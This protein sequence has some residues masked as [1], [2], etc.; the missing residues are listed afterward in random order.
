[1]GGGLNWSRGG[2]LTLGPYFSYRYIGADDMGFGDSDIFTGGL[3]TSYQLAMWL[4]ATAGAQ[5]H[6]GFA[7]DGLY[8]LAGYQLRLGFHAHR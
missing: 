5:F 6:M 3:A 7:N 8:D 4:R 2:A 1:M